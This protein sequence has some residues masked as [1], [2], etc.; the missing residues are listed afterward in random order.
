MK[1]QIEVKIPTKAADLRIKHFKSMSMAPLDPILHGDEGL[2]FLASFT[3]LRNSQLLDFRVE[4]IR[5]MTA[6]ALAT[7]SKMD[8]TSKLPDT[9]KLAGTSYRL[10]NPDKV[11][12]GWHIDFKNCDIN[13][14]PVRL[15]CMFYLQEGFNYSDVDENDNIKFPIASRHEIFAEHFPLDLFIRASGFFLRRSLNSMKR[16]M[17]SK[18]SLK[19]KLRQI[20]PFN[21]KQLLKQS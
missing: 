10:V 15:A 6:T 13:K 8:L 3:G 4:D 12:I 18:L 19:Q 9:I 5:T 20:N 11:G 17:E 7:L 14:D 1:K 21:G 2:H 16:S